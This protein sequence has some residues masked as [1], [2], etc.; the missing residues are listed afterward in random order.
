MKQPYQIL[1]RLDDT[2][3]LRSWHVFF[4]GWMVGML[5]ASVLDLLL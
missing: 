4:I 3:E 1:E 2:P 5:F